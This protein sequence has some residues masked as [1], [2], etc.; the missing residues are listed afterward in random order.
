MSCE[1]GMRDRFNHPA[2]RPIWDEMVAALHVRDAATGRRAKAEAF[3]AYK[4]AGA[5]Y[6]A[7]KA[8]LGL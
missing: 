1:T 3:A 2:L 5:R 7:T 6:R 8:A 4:E